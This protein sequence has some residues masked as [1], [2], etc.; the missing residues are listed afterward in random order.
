MNYYL[1]EKFLLCQEAENLEW[2]STAVSLPH[3][4]IVINEVTYAELKT[5]SGIYINKLYT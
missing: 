5:V 1:H 3:K 2:V 4:V